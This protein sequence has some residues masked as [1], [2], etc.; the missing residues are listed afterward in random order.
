MDVH[1][2]SPMDKWRQ[3]LLLLLPLRD[4]EP[5][6]PRLLLAAMWRCLLQEEEEEEE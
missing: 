1:A 5:I 4:M 2:M 6:Q 3:V